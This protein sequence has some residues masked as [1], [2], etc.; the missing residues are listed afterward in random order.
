[1]SLDMPSLSILVCANSAVLINRTGAN[2]AAVKTFFMV[3]SLSFKIMNG[4]S[5]ADESPACV[6]NSLPRPFRLQ[7]VN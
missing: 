4:G 3:K 5:L 7:T 1:M 2:T 6:V